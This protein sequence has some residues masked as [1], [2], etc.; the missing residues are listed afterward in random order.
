MA[1]D[2]QI[3]ANRNNARRSTG[4]KTATGRASVSRN[5]VKHG[6]TARRQN[7]LGDEDGK[8]YDALL[9][10]LVEALRPVGPLEEEL[11]GRAAD[12]SWRLRRAGRI[13]TALLEHALRESQLLRAE[14]RLQTSSDRIYR[15]GDF[16]SDENRRAKADYEKKR[17]ALSRAPH[18]LGEAFAKDADGRNALTK[19]SRYETALWNQLKEVLKELDSLQSRRVEPAQ[20]VETLHPESPDETAQPGT[21]G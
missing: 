8:A 18:S 15:P 19:L 12:L 4:P 5:A 6:L 20:V 16:D 10:G 7:L 1:T 11:C 17:Q 14:R 2:K 13:E 9:H 21:L 3:Q